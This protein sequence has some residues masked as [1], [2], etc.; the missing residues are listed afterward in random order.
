MTELLEDY[1]KEVAKYPRFINLVRSTIVTARRAPDVVY[2]YGRTGCGKTRLVYDS[3]DLQEIYPV[4]FAQ[5]TIW[6]DGYFDQPVCLFDD[7][8]GQVKPDLLL[9]LL[10]RYP[11]QV[12][13]KGSFVWWNP[14][15]IIIT[16]NLPPETLYPTIPQEVRD[17]VFRRLGRLVD[18][19]NARKLGPIVLPPT[20]EN[21]E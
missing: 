14:R 7:F 15:I 17:A 8:Y 11:L 21:L 13:I 1:T 10:D 2:I 3:Y 16:S 9:R 6:F 5:K 18:F 12:P 4:S 20:S 19:E